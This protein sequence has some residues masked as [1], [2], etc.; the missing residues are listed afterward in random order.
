MKKLFIIANWKSNKTLDE[1]KDWLNKFSDHLKSESI[2]LSN[3]EIIICPSFT[4]LG[5]LSDLNRSLNLPIKLGA[6]DIS[7]FD[8]GAY[9]GEI[10]GGQIK[11]LADYA[12]IG[13][14]ERR[15]NFNESDET[16]F[17]KADQARKFAVIPVFCIQNENTTIPENISVIAY[18]P[19]SA[20]GTGHPD[21]PENA[22]KIAEM[23]K[24]K[25]NTQ[26]V[27]YGGSVKSENVKSFSD[28]PNIDGF[29]VGGAS[30]NPSDFFQI[31]KNA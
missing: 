4:L 8:Q 24:S 3:K 9:T 13:H 19:P 7:P 12:I 25:Y 30:L 5:F 16:I 2:D 26:F 14:S 1:A 20:I 31:V 10:Y 29:L 6:Q 11:E 27:L 23:V 21:T 28:M 15:Q 22:D 17:K 18:E